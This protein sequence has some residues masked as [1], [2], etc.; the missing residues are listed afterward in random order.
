MP[1]FESQWHSVIVSLQ[2]LHYISLTKM[3]PWL[4]QELS[5]KETH[6]CPLPYMLEL[7]FLFYLCQIWIWVENYTGRNRGNHNGVQGG[8]VGMTVFTCKWFHS[9]TLKHKWL[10][11]GFWI[12]NWIAPTKWICS[13]GNLLENTTL[14]W[15]TKS[16]WISSMPWILM[17][18][19]FV[20]T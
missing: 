10:R 15:C 16:T 20:I 4:K 13:P 7:N 17:V 14:L 1:A 3:T 12:L 19:T 11:E 5:M 8:K 6:C 2:L 18:T 9:G